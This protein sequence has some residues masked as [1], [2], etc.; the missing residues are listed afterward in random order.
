MGWKKTCRP[1]IPS[2]MSGLGYDLCF[3]NP[4]DTSLAGAL[5]EVFSLTDHQPIILTTIGKFSPENC[6]ENLTGKIVQA[7]KG[8]DL[9]TVEEL[10][11]QGKDVTR[12]DDVGQA[13]SIVNRHCHHLHNFRHHHHCYQ[14]LS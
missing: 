1:D 12:S 5:I 10:V 8:D 3:F 7:V 11:S 2:K 6:C 13:S 14:G 4:E 9:A